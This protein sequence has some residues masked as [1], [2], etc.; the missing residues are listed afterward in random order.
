MKKFIFFCICLIFPFSVYALDRLEIDNFLIDATIK[1]D[2]SMHVKELFYVKGDFSSFERRVTYK[3]SSYESHEQAL[4]LKDTIYNGSRLNITRVS[5]LNVDD[6]ITYDTFLESF[7][8]FNK[9]YYKEDAEDKEYVE[10]GVQDGKDLTLYYTNNNHKT[11]FL[12]EYDIQNVIVKHLDCEELY[13][14]FLKAN[15]DKDLPSFSVRIHFPNGIKEDTFKSYL[16]GEVTGK[17]VFLDTKTIQMNFSK[18]SHNTEISSRFVFDKD[19]VLNVASFKQ[20][21]LS[22]YQDI[23]LLEDEQTKKETK[24]I[25]K[26]RIITDVIM[27]FCKTYLICLFALWFLFLLKLKKSFS[28]KEEMSDSL[29]YPIAIVSMVFSLKISK[30]SFCMTILE[31]FAK[32]NIE[33]NKN[34]L[35]LKNRD[36]LNYT[37]EM[38]LEFLF[39]KVGHDNKLSL[40]EF[41]KYLTNP[42]TCLS[43]KKFYTNWTR[44]VKKEMDKCAFYEKNG[45]AII[46][47][48]FALLIILFVLFA[49]IYF[50]VSYILPWIAFL[51]TL[52]F[53]F[54]CFGVSPKTKEGRRV[55]KKGQD[56][57][58]SFD[59]DLSSLDEK[60]Y[61]TYYIY[62]YYWN[63]NEEVYEKMQTLLKKEPLVNRKQIGT[64]KKMKQ[65]SLK[66]QYA[67]LLNDEM[68]N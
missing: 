2:G 31:L 3:T 7:Q 6:D 8:N 19:T 59:T 27:K 58:N 38:V 54:F 61:L 49:S 42:K 16:H 51:I 50:K 67:F 4:L 45:L 11:A 60:D 46:I 43:F 68:T 20:S 18:V 53:V 55:T 32:K 63:K 36:N 24:E 34:Y 1:D 12:I 21:G 26:K 33:F 62:S 44:C 39:E 37:E 9:K 48:I 65:I 47:S 17:T 25:K 40:N 23:I 29:S 56:M 35:I 57:K 22:R 30:N 15:L 41:H 28:I 52:L 14:S 66:I 13:W 5:Y 10:S 64:L